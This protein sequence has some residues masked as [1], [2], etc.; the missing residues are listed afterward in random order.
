VNGGMINAAGFYAGNVQDI[1]LA[2]EQMESNR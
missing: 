2:L 1:I